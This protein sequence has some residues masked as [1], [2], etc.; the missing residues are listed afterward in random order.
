MK[1]STA[2]HNDGERRLGRNGERGSR[3]RR[4]TSE[5]SNGPLP[6]ADAIGETNAKRRSLFPEAD[7]AIE[8]PLLGA[9]G[10]ALKYLLEREEREGKKGLS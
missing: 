6:A 2:R 9:R 5:R 3:Q 8:N 7:F 10:A 1:G 4:K